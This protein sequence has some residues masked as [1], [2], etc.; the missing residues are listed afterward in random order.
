MK[1]LFVMITSVFV[2]LTAVLLLPMSVYA[3]EQPQTM[4]VSI[5]E[6]AVEFNGNYYKLIDI[7]TDWEKA[8]KYCEALGGHLATITS[9]AEDNACSNVLKNSEYID[10][11]L[12][13]YEDSDTKTWKWVTGEV[14]NYTNWYPNNPNVR[15]KEARLQYW[16]EKE[17][18][19][20]TFDDVEAS[21]RQPFIC[22]WEKENAELVRVMYGYV[23]SPGRSYD[24]AFYFN[25]NMYKEYIT[26]GI[27]YKQWS[28][29]G[30]SFADVV[31]DC[32]QK[33]GHI[34]T[35]G[36]A[37]EDGAV[38]VHIARDG[39]YTSSRAILGAVYGDNGWEWVHG[40]TFDYTNFR[41]KLDN[42]DQ[43]LRY[44]EEGKWESTSLYYQ[45]GNNNYI[46][47]VCEWDNCCLLPNGTIGTHNYG[48]AKKI[49]D[50]TCTQYEKWQKT[51]LTCGISHISETEILPHQYEDEGKTGGFNAIIP[52]V[53]REQ[54]CTV[55]K[56]VHHYEDWSNV[57]VLVVVMAA[58]LIT[59][60]VFMIIPREHLY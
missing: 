19:T 23:S 13:A 37:K 48:E 54:V 10:C 34:V 47:Y 36:S 3:E 52:P 40:D 39:M 24:G 16:F 50:A 46:G 5:L 30:W 9:Q 53:L 51:C 33:G 32:H 38:F 7:K 59:Y 57:W 42:D 26:E 20:V 45:I 55:C 31:E 58:V 29:K 4:V 1:K 17:S 28:E 22:E 6:D 8:K 44:S 49:A 11:W 27:N 43:Y 15:G 25:G 18:D 60:I 35:I 14:W 2:L 21:Q 56:N 12:G 41:H